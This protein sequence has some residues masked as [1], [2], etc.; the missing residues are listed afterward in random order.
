MPN[1][2]QV[3]LPLFMVLKSINRSC[4]L[5]SVPKDLPMKSAIF[6]IACNFSGWL[7]LDLL[8]LCYLFSMS[9]PTTFPSKF[10]MGVFRTS[11]K[12]PLF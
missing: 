11:F 3:K 2:T 8:Y 5:H 1:A 12:V 4:K 9:L 6:V 7:V 10:C